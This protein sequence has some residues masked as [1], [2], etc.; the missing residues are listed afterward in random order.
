MIESMT[1]MLGILPIAIYLL[2]DENVCCYLDRRAINVGRT[3]A[4]EIQRAPLTRQS[5]W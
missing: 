1:E 5:N 4:A 2:P 3:W